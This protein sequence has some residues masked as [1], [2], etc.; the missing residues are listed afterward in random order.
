MKTEVVR[1]ARR[2]KTIEAKVVDGVLR[3][4]MPDS[5]S[6]ADE[7]RWVATM[8][9]RIARKLQATRVDLPKR[10]RQLAQSLSLPQARQIVFSDRQRSR[11]GSCTPADGRIRIS[12]RLA[13]YP[14]W[15]LD[16]V[17]VHELA[18]L[19]EPN[20]SPTFWQ[21]VD[22]YPLSERARGY[23]IAKGEDPSGDRVGENPTG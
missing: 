2:K 8:Q 12:N 23:L 13:D 1:S 19:A 17:I 16:Y 22:R 20:H 14:P 10:A 9:Q 21:L 7:A 3:V 15:V 11:W 6:A 4:L 18:H 5:L